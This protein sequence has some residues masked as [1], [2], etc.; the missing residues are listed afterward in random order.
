[1]RQGEG[2]SYVV[3]GRSERGFSD[4]DLRSLGNRG[5]KLIGDDANDRSGFSVSGGWGCEWGWV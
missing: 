5:F 2:I 3:F 1:M 4:I